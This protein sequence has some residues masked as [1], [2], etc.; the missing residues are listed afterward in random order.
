MRSKSL[1]ALSM[2]GVLL[3]T[4]CTDNGSGDDQYRRTKQGAIIGAIGGAVVGAAANGSDDREQALKG[5]II[6]GIGGAIVGSILDKQAQDLRR[7]LPAN[8]GVDRR[9]DELVVTMAQDLLFASDSAN[10]NY[11]QR[12]EL[13]TVAQSLLNYPSTTVYVVGHTDS[14]ASAAYNQDL[15]ERRAAAVAFE[16]R[17]GGVPAGRI[18]AFGR[19]ESQPIATNQT[20]AGKARNRRVEI[21]IREQ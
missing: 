19:G 12:D 9:G 3:I 1:L 21:I 8:V 18:S 16:L 11:N 15:S 10:L 5:A 13:R 14:T 17:S 4:A 6:G 2:S 7:D 20:E